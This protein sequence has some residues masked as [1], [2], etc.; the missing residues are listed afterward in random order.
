MF[1][2][3]ALNNSPAAAASGATVE[4]PST[5]ISAEATGAAVS[6]DSAFVPPQAVKSR[7]AGIATAANFNLR[8]NIISFQYK[9]LLQA[10]NY[11]D[12]VNKSSPFDEQGM[13]KHF[14]SYQMRSCF[15]NK[16]RYGA[17][18]HEDFGL[19]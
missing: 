12:H 5:R 4:E 14:D 19:C 18:I 6:V 15:T 16:M 10:L 1:G 11:R 2:F 8:R 13:N 7:A 17:G 9:G 3:S